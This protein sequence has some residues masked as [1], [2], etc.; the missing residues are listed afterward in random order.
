MDFNITVDPADPAPI[1]DLLYAQTGLS[2][3]E[4]GQIAGIVGVVAISIAWLTYRWTITANR[5][6]HM[7]N[8]FREYVQMAFTYYDKDVAR[9]ETHAAYSYL[10][11]YKMWVLEEI[12]IWTTRVHPLTRRWLPRHKRLIEN[13]RCTI[14]HQLHRD[15]TAALWEDFTASRVCY[16]RDFVAFAE[17]WHPFSPAHRAKHPRC[18]QCKHT[19]PAAKPQP[20]RRTPRKKPAAPKAA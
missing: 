1:A 4:L 12:W 5:A 19:A 16:H 2:L 10:A 7:S 17:E 15:E 13:W 9:D 3:T 20:A 8:L 11:D 18:T 14:I 6:S